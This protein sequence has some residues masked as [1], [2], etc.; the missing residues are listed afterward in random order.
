M[1]AASG[2]ALLAPGERDPWQTSTFGTGQ[3]IRAA[4]EL[5]AGAVILGVGGSATHDLGLGILSALGLS[6]LTADGQRLEAPVPAAW[7]R[8]VRIE[9]EVMT[10]LPPIRLACD[11]ANPLLGPSGAAAVFAPQKG[12]AASDYDRLEAES[13][14]IAAMLCVHCERSRDLMRVPGAGAAG[15]TAFGLMAGT[16]A[17]LLAGSELVTTWLDLDSRLA[18]ARPRPHRGRRLRHDWNG[19]GARRARP[20]GPGAG[21]T[22]ARVRRTGRNLAGRT[23]VAL[24]GIT[25]AGTTLTDALR[26]GGPNLLAS[27]RR[28]F[29]P[30]SGPGPSGG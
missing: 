23:G 19:K 8:L 10:S 28:A 11:V 17:R 9:G 14:R 22:G 25:P 20:A 13:A 27:V 29:A 30:V 2:L 6:F 12:L 15:G 3:L 18:A 16:G 26:C 5:G 21:Q 24:H 4:A 7:P 1:A